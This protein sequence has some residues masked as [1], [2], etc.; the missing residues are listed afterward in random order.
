MRKTNSLLAV[1]ML[2][3]V[4]VID[5]YG[6]IVDSNSPSEIVSNPLYECI[7]E[8]KVEAEN[9]SGEK[10]PEVYNTILQIGSSCAKFGDYTA[11]WVDSISQMKEV[12]ESLRKEYKNKQY[13]ASYYFDAIIYQNSP[14]NKLTVVDVIT[15]NL[16]TYEERF[17]PFEWELSQDTSSVCGYVC[18]KATTE[19]GGRRWIVWYAADIPASYGPWKFTGLPGLVLAACDGEGIH[20][21]NA[22]SIRKASVLITKEKNAKLVGTT[23][24]KFIKNKNHFEEDPM[25]NIPVESISKMEVFRYGEGPKDKSAFING[26]QLRMRPNGYTPLELK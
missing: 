12:D 15:P 26:V 1:T 11:Y 23:R 7:Y 9:K 3:A 4:T 22:I 16:F 8:Y 19:Y 20:E 17:S 25:H 21:F 18:N 10:V 13:R 5:T 6:Q 14:Q 24:E 2:C